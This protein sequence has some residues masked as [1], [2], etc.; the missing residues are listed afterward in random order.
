MPHGVPVVTVGTTQ[1]A[2]Q[3]RGTRTPSVVVVMPAYNA[4]K[5]IERTY[6]DIPHD[7]V[8][9]IILVDD[10]SADE[11]VEIAKHL[12]LDVIVHPQ[13]RGYGGNQKT[14]YDP[15]LAMGAEIV[16][17]LHPDYQ[18]DATRIPALIEPVQ[19]GSADLVLVRSSGL[20]VTRVSTTPV[21]LEDVWPSALGSGA[22]E[23]AMRSQ[24]L[25]GRLA[26]TLF[27]FQWLIVAR[28]S[29]D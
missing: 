15:A 20:T 29:P 13:N 6:D 3:S 1:E 27:A 8:D 25:A 2:Q 14:C 21:P 22:R 17:M 12:G 18:Y 16:V 4:A 23:L 26:P 19:D 11:T 24:M 28:R 7:L 9:E 10:V 5:T